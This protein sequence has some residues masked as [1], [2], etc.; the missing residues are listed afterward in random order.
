MS[1]IATDPQAEFAENEC[2]ELTSFCPECGMWALSHCIEEQPNGALKPH[3]SVL[4]LHCGYDESQA[5]E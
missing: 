3:L 2:D 4:C 5:L 1:V